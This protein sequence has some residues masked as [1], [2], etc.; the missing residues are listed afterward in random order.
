MARP[1]VSVIVLTYN[2]ESSLRACLASVQSQLDEVDGE[3]L[4]IDNASTDGTVELARSID[5]EP[6][7][8]GRNLGFAA[9]CNLGARH[10]VGD[11]L[12]FVN[13]DTVLDPGCLR[14]LVA[15]ARRE[16]AGPLGGRAHGTDGTY[17]PRSVLG[18]PSLRGA[19]CFAVGLNTAT[20]GSPWTDPEH[21]PLRVPA[22]GSARSVPAISGALLAISRSLWEELQGFDETY[23][24]YGEDV[25][26]SI[27]A[28]DLGWQPT[29]VTAA[30]YG[31]VGGVSSGSGPGRDV[32]LYQGKAELYWQHLPPV[33]AR[34]AVGALQVGVFLRGLP[35]Q[36]RLSRLEARAEP[37]WTLHLAR[38][39]WRAGY[40]TRRVRS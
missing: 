12:V 21:G 4:L 10:G 1:K 25:D 36:L 39:A 33:A 37:W 7:E 23:F 30:G 14:A 35:A 32:L 13:P 15:A 27:R 24:L 22:D 31:H 5:A 19:L 20:R 34:T 40:R 3:L 11:L 28:V 29:L 17:D 38:G 2:S 8:A 18:R 26:L 6:I 16:T 9:G